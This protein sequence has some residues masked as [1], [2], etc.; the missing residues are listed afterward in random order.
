MRIRYST[1][2][3]VRTIAVVAAVSFVVDVGE[4]A[5]Q[6]IAVGTIGLVFQ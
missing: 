2:T 3:I 1:E 5:L 6:S 4:I